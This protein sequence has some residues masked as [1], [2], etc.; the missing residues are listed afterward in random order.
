M[1][2]LVDIYIGI[3][4]RKVYLKDVGEAHTRLLCFGYMLKDV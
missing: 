4:I 2:E 1:M 3:G